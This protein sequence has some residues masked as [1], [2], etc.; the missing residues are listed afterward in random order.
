MNP[1][2]WLGGGVSETTGT[3]LPVLFPL[4][5]ASDAFSAADIVTTYAKILTDTLERTHGLSKKVEP[6]LFDNCVQ[7]ESGEG[8]VTLL[9]KAMAQMSD[10]FLVYKA[11][12]L[13]RATP[14]EEALIRADYG[15][16]KNGGK[17]SVGVWISFKGYRRTEMLLVYSA[18]EYCVLASLNK[19]MNLAKAVQIKIND[20]RVSTALSDSE[21]AKAQMIAIATALS[22]GR[23]VGLDAKDTVEVP[24]VDMAPTEKAMAFLH[25][26]RAFILSLPT[27]YISGDQTPGIGSTGEADMRAVER[28]L[29]AQYYGPIVRPA[30]LALFG[31]ATEFKSQ[32]FR[33]ITSAVE[34]L[35][36]FDLASDDILPRSKKIEIV[37]RM[38]GA[39]L[40]EIEKALEAQEKERPQALPSTGSVVEGAPSA[41]Q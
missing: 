32:D 13:R 29:K 26:K 16:V 34:T 2:R 33:Q 31:A 17:S 3:H 25:A 30:L 9:A 19:S 11:D 18:L 1:F 37:A 40:A 12:V 41:A 35:Q 20:L 38:F 21:V 24:K 39:D 5:I 8:L 22:Q 28:G 15:N 14:D 27:S 6:L 23:D 36:A 10:L 7:S 4:A